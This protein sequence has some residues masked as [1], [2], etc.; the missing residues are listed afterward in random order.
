MLC[1]IQGYVYTERG[2]E[3]RGGNS[4]AAQRLIPSAVTV[5]VAGSPLVRELRPHVLAGLARK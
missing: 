2:Y 3:M 5:G 4:R 1:H